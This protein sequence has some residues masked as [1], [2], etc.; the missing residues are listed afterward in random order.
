MVLSESKFKQVEQIQAIQHP[1]VIS[2]MT[3]SLYLTQRMLAYAKHNAAKDFRWNIFVKV[4]SGTQRCGFDITATRSEQQHA[5]LLATVELI[6][7]N[8]EHLRLH[9]VYQYS[10]K[11]YTMQGEA[12]M[13][14]IFE[15][16][17]QLLVRC[18]GEVE[19]EC[20]V[21]VPI[22][23]SGST[24]SCV[25]V[26]NFEGITEV[27]PGNYVFY[28]RMQF[29]FGICDDLDAIPI[30]LMTRIIGRYP[31]RNEVVVDCG[32]VGVSLDKGSE[33]ETGYGCVLGHEKLKLYS[34]S[35]EVGKITTV[36]GSALDFSDPRLQY[37]SVLRL[38]PHHSCLMAAQHPFYYVVNDED[39]VLDVYHK[40]GGW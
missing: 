25:A 3:D 14:R 24:P 10:N 22:V 29:D 38:I 6:R 28:D 34:M 17:R 35:Q 4:D 7:D 13:R 31:Q 33:V 18:L 9:G 23:S 39:K 8:D 11:T 27:H 32:S 37:G 19:G 21:R 30:S 16:E 36:D 5:D 1:Q 20:R 40:V 15:E 2:V 12:A 26:D